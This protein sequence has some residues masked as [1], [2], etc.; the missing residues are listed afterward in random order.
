MVKA[1]EARARQGK[2]TQAVQA[3]QTAW[4]DG[5]PAEARNYFRVA[6]Q[7]E[8]WNLLD[9]A[10]DFAEQGVK[11]A[12][13]DLLAS[14]ENHHG[15]AIY[16][17]I[18]ARQRRSAEVLKTLEAAVR[19]ADVS[20]SSPAMVLQQ[21]E[22]QGIASVSDAEWRRNRVE[23]RK[24]QAQAGF[25]EAVLQTSAVAAKYYT[26]EEKLAYA[27]LLDG[28]R[29]N[30]PQEDV[31]SVWIPAAMTAGLKDREAQW[32]KDVLLGDKKFDDGKLNAFNLLEKQRMENTERGDTL[33]KICRYISAAQRRS[34]SRPSRRRLEGRSEPRKGTGCAAQNGHSKP[35]AG[36]LAR[37]I[38]RSLVA[39]RTESS[40]SSR[41]RGVQPITR[42]PP[43]T[44]SSPGE[45]SR[46]PMRQLM[47]GAKDLQ[48]VWR[49]ANTALAGL[50]FSDK[51]PAIDTAFQTV[52]D[53]RNIGE[54]VS[55]KP[56]SSFR[57]D[58]K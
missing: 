22:K 11:Q 36:E 48:P 50:Y 32:R 30:A 47:L 33:E 3:L 39:V 56:D 25:R 45:R 35:S 57:L 54:R 13:D 23:Q 24:Q 44:T 49:L 7:L 17:R 55:T 5:R 14:G 6:E 18:L 34:G 28:Y 20:P 41:H 1:A 31:V 21:A 51:T 26:P 4:I 10:N 29:A 15:A 52:L 43:P 9:D 58:R 16:A 38:L 19:A 40:W 42:M 2:N 53:D 8:K 37:T 27:Q 12:G 46:W